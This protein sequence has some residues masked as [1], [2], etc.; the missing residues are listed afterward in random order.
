M[1]Y[2]KFDFRLISKSNEKIYNRSG[3]F[4]LSPKFKAFEHKV[5]LFARLQYRGRPVTN[6]VE[7]MIGAHYTNKVHGD[8]GNLCKS[9]CDS[10]NKL[11]WAD[12]RQIKKL[13]ITVTENNDRDWFEVYVQ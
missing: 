12:D 5:A 8:T 10:F 2:L 11:I 7:V 6:N 13:T 4:F 1:I 3:R 9:L